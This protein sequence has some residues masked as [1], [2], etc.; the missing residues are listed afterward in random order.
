MKQKLI[1]GLTTELKNDIDGK[2]V[3]TNYPYVDAILQAGAVPLLLPITEMPQ[4]TLDCLNVLNGIVFIG[5]EDIAPRFFGENPHPK[6][7]EVCIERD[8]S[9]LA[10]FHAAYER[11]IPMLGI[12]RGM[13]LFNIALGGTLYQDIFSEKNDIMAHVSPSTL[14]E[15]FHQIKL[16]EDG[17]LYRIYKESTLF[18]NTYHHQAIKA[19]GRDLKISA[20]AYDGIIEA[21]ETTTDRILLATQFHPEQMIYKRKELLKIFEYFIGKIAL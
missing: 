13:Q 1:I 17:F 15:G 21:I 14:E 19:M 10:L 18:V 4:M 7:H 9:E 12:C 8:K 2:C 3:L 16:E 5:G 11:K 6:I 20:R